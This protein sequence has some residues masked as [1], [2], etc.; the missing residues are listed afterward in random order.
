LA[1]AFLDGEVVHFVLED[2]AGAGRH[3]SRA[4]PGVYRE[5]S[6]R[7]VA[8]TIPYGEMGGIAAL[9]VVGLAVR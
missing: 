7:A 8:V 1:A 3:A 5:R 6:G 4:I 9:T 2:D